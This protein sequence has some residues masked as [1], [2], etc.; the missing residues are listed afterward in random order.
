MDTSSTR[1]RIAQALVVI[2]WILLI[3]SSLSIGR[4][5]GK[6]ARSTDVTNFLSDPSQITFGPFFGYMFG[7]LLLASPG[8]I[9]GFTAWS[10]GNLSSGK[11]LA[12]VGLFVLVYAALY[13]LVP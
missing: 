11:W 3:V 4:F 10:L 1:T 5:E 8:A 7:V 13:N 12:I 6:V 2:G 9:L